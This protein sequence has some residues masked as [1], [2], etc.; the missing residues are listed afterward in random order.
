MG[1]LRR[2]ADALCAGSDHFV[3]NCVKN[4]LAL[5]HPTLQDFDKTINSKAGGAAPFPFDKVEDYYTWASSHTALPSVKTP[6]VIINAKDDPIVQRLPTTGDNP[7]VVMVVTKN[8][9]HL[10]WFEKK[11]GW[12]K[13][14]RWIGKPVTEFLKMSGELVVFESKGAAVYVDEADGFIKLKERDDIGCKVV[15]GGGI[16]DGVAQDDLF[17]GL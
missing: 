8:G 7:Y 9:G 14:R 17:Q 5:K 6:L 10:G 1:L 3:T 12:M 13:A 2:N 16:V 4:T 15:P 11:P